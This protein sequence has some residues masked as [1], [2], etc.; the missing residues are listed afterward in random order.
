MHAISNSHD[1]VV[2]SDSLFFFPPRLYPLH[3]HFICSLS[4][5]GRTP[6]TVTI[7]CFLNQVAITLAFHLF[8]FLL[9]TRE[10]ICYTAPFKTV[11]DKC[12]SGSTPI[13]TQ[14]S[15]TKRPPLPRQNETSSETRSTWIDHHALCDPTIFLA[16]VCKASRNSQ[17]TMS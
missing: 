8:F 6:I 4:I 2:T 9:V 11:N 13:N 5:G 15:V 12:G 16:R 10:R 14:H 17:S 7:C 1:D 3:T